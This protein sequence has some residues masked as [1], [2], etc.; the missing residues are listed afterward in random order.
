VNLC[1]KQQTAI[2]HQ[3]Q[4]GIRNLPEQQNRSHNYAASFHLYMFRKNDR[5]PVPV[6]RS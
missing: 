1:Q 3:K 5:K 6:F 4:N 2:L